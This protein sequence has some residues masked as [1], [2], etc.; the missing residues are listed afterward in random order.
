[1][2]VVGLTGGIGAGKSTLAHV[3]AE[4]GADV[5][6][7]D[8]IGPE[9]IAEDG[10]GAADVLARF[11]TLDRRELAAQVFSNADARADLEA[12]SWPLIEAELRR[13]VT[14]SMAEVVV[15]DM[16]VLGQGLGE[17][18]YGPV[19]TVEANEQLRLSRLVD[20][21]MTV[22]DA[23]PRMAAQVT[24]DTRRSI[25]DAVVLNEGDLAD[26]ACEA[27]RVLS[28]LHPQRI[29]GSQPSD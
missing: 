19:V 7:V 4:R 25:A 11:G 12:V 2:I 15:L 21:G 10:P 22:E 26:L 9:V 16:A 5:V 3:F 20:R 27:D 1:V 28:N 8:A 18:L 6:D 17:G 23:R 24:E 14:A 13:R 29:R